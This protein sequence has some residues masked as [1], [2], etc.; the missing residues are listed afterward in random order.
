MA[1]L[2]IQMYLLK[3]TSEGGKRRNKTVP[4]PNK[5]DEEDDRYVLKIVFFRNS[6]YPD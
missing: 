3:E 4:Y 1:T 5:Y 6:P 2:S